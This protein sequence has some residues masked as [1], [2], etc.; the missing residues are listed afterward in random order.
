MIHKTITERYK[1]I[2]GCNIH[3]WRMHHPE[4]FDKNNKD[5]NTV[6]KNNFSIWNI[7]G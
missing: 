7:S 4:Q 2:T 1:R 3:F 5:G 6:K